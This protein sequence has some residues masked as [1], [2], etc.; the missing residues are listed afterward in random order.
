VVV[1]GVDEGLFSADFRAPERLGQLLI[2]VS[3]RAGR[4]QRAGRVL[5][6]THHPQHP[7]LATLMAGGY[8]ALAAEL[9]AERR[10]LGYPPYAHW[11]VLRAEAPEEED[12]KT[13]LGGVAELAAGLPEAVGVELLGPLPAPKPRRAGFLRG[14]LVLG[15]P[16]RPVLQRLLGRL[17]PLLH[18]LPGVR[19]VRWS[20]DVDPVD[21]Y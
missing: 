6:Q 1:V 5:L 17:S 21:L 12:W 19:R 15:A 20:L 11:A 9:L 18:D 7:L 10:Q 14:Q 3:G 4:G 8:S 13:F 16:Q 2:Q